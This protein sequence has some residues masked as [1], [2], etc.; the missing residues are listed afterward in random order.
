MP[1]VRLEREFNVDVE[2]LFKFI[3]TTEKLLQ[4]WGPEGIKVESHAL[5]LSKPGPWFAAMISD[6]GNRYKMS[7]QVTHVSPPKSI[8]FTW[9]WHDDEDKRGDESHVT[10]T[11]EASDQ[12]ARLVIDHRDLSDTE[13]ATRHERGWT[14][15][16]RKLESLLT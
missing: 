11:V 2:T 8:G 16:L 1:D 3:S 13:Q 9:G 5:D 6:E 15:T 12:G 14:S 7:G 4:W 10:F